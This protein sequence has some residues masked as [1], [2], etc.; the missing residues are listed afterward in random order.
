MCISTSVTHA[1]RALCTNLMGQCL[2]TDPYPSPPPPA[3]A[4]VHLLHFVPL[5]PELVDFAAP[6]RRTVQT[7]PSRARGKLER[8]QIKSFTVLMRIFLPIGPA[9]LEGVKYECVQSSYRLS[10][11][12]PFLRM[13]S[14]PMI[15]FSSMS[16]PLSRLIPEDGLFGAYQV[17]SPR[18][19]I[20]SP[21][22]AALL[23]NPGVGILLL[24]GRLLQ[25]ISRRC[26]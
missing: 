26:P 8:R 6:V 9:S 16:H 24:L 25:L 3:H 2:C 10:D 12:D 19:S 1:N 20:R 17:P 4:N 22:S 15:T 14:S 18:G 21:P 13:V 11:G 23:I 5:L 7:R